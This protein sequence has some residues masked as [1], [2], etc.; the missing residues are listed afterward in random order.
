M[1]HR[2]ITF[3]FLEKTKIIKAKD[4]EINEQDTHTSIFLKENLNIYIYLRDI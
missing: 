4:Y 1:Q 2:D 3:H